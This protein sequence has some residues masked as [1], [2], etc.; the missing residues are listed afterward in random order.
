VKGRSGSV[1]AV[2][3]LMILMGVVA[4]GGAPSVPGP[5]PTAPPRVAVVGDPGST[6]VTAALVFPGS[7]WELPGTEGLTLLAAETL[8]E[9]VRGR[10]EALGARAGVRCDRA[11]FTFTMVAPPPV[12]SEALDI[13][14]DGLFRPEPGPA[15]L[16]AARDRVRSALALDHASPAWQARL[17]ARQAL[18]GDTM[19]ASAWESPPC[20]V[21]E[22]LDLHDLARVR[23]GALRFAPR[24]ARGVALVGAVDTAAARRAL[25]ARLPAG[26]PPPLPAPAAMGPGRR[27]VERNTITAW[28]AHAFPFQGPVDEEALRLLGSLLAEE[29]GPG[30][31]R[32]GV[33]ATSWELERHGAGGALI[34]HMVTAPGEAAGHAGELL[35]RMREVARDG[36]RG[37]VLERVELRHRGHRLQQ[38]EAPES[39]AAA[40]AQSL[41]LGVAPGTWTGWPESRPVTAERVHRT[42]AALGPPA[43]SVVG[44]RSA[45]DAVAP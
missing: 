45:R 35:D 36:V 25:Q 40:L 30:V 17:A 21:P 20:G 32:P 9:E 29:L 12:W 3:L 14:L 11:M 6:A 4:C 13:L 19:S 31:S 39:R 26:A 38:L 5:V 10:L 41:A 43:R 37:R 34:V 24:M 2:V 28:V 15:S 16:A 8:L 18:Y 22:S 27:Y 44:P 42:A 33:F 1:R 7:G 23:A